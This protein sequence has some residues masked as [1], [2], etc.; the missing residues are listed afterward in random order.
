MP[1]KII[2]HG[3]VQGVG[4]RSYCERTALAMR[5]HGSATNNP[6]GT[7]SVVLRTD[8]EK[9]SSDYAEALRTN[10]FGLR[11]WGNFRRIEVFFCGENSDGDYNW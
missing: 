11:F 9:K 7:V 10:K 5:L 4:C 8:D 1:Y 6:D 2:L 3:N